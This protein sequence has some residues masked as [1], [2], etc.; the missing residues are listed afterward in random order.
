MIEVE[1]H[2]IC[3]KAAGHFR[4]RDFYA[5]HMFALV[6]WIWNRENETESDI[7]KPRTYTAYLEISK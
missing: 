3:V 5:K 1:I 6:N 4:I 7:S 2:V